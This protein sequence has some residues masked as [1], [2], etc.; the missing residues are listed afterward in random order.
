MSIAVE[1]KINP[2]EDE[3][4]LEQMRRL[5]RAWKRADDKVAALHAER[6]DMAVEAYL[7]GWRRVTIMQEL[8][9]TDATLSVWL[10]AAGVAQTRPRSRYST[11]EEEAAARNA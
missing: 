7:H 4:T 1:G 9:I 5:G 3:P 6:R 2:M 10:K 11:P 8:H